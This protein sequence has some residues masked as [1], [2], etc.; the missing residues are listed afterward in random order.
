[1]SCSISVCLATYNGE[2]FIR[3]QLTSVLSQLGKEDEIIVTD[4]SSTDKTLEIIRS[5]DD[6]RIKIFANNTFHSP[7]FNFENALKHSSGNYIFLCDQD[8]IWLPNKVEIFIEKLSYHDLVVSDCFLVD[9]NADIIADSYYSI[10]P[11][12]NGLLNNLLHNHYLGCCM[13]FKRDV[14]RK[15]LPFPA[16]IAMHDIWIGLCAEAFY[17]P[18]FIPNKLIKY[19][20]HGGNASSTG[21]GSHYSIFY[22][23]FYRLYFLCQIILRFFKM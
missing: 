7:V 17:N 22:C 10:S 8:D 3:E 13:A 19:R 11:P 16:H 1:M 6:S 4:D 5:F 23:V 15:I 20:R 2:K 12:K 21:E 18:I 9:I 14:L